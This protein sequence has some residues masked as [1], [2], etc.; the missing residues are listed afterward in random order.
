MTYMIFLN[1]LKWFLV[2]EIP[3]CSF[4]VVHCFLIKSNK[5]NLSITIHKKGKICSTEAH[6]QYKYNWKN[7][8]YSSYSLFG[9]K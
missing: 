9:K 7:P 5:L 3:S 4:E 6:K 1:I 8:I 2:R